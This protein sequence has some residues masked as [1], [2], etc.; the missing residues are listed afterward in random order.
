MPNKKRERENSSLSSTILHD[1]TTAFEHLHF[2]GGE[3]Q[4]TVC[5]LV[6]SQSRKIK[7]HNTTRL[8]KT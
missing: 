2:E 8:A 1:R 5:V 3:P 6:V 7:K 4:S